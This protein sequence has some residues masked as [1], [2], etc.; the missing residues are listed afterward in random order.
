MLASFRKIGCILRRKKNDFFS[1]FLPENVKS[2]EKD[3]PVP[4]VAWVG[5]GA[6]KKNIW[7]RRM[8]MTMKPYLWQQKVP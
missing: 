7:M 3:G 8:M 4:S 1:R 6:N 5:G 2:D